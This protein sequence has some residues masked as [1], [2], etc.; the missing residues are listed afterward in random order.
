MQYKYNLNH[1]LSLLPAGVYPDHIIA[2]LELTYE[3]P[4]TTFFKDRYLTVRDTDEIPNER[5][6]IYAQVLGVRVED[7]FSSRPALI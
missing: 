7:L 6:V 5:L 3:I 2:L 1:F 4:S